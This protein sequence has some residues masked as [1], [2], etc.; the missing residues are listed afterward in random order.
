VGAQSRAIVLQFLVE[1]LVI[2]VTG[3][4][5]GV[6]IAIGL[7]TL[8]GMLLIDLNVSVQM[9]SIVLAFAVSASIGIFFGIYPAQRAARLNPIEA[10]RYE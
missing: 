10:L 1:A 8:A 9:G 5:I 3:G 4:A 6:L 2:A 7:T